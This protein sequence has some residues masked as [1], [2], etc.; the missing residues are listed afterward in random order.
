[1]LNIYRDSRDSNPLSCTFECNDKTLKK[2]S[3]F[4]RKIEN[5]RSKRS[6]N[7]YPVEVSY[8][9]FNEVVYNCV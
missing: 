3:A 8:L 4:Y 7:D 9:M 6:V 1:M 5:Y 2:R